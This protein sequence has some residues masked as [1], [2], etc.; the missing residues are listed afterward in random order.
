MCVQRTT[1]YSI[2]SSALLLVIR[3]GTVSSMSSC[4]CRRCGDFLIQIAQQCG[5]GRLKGTLSVTRRRVVICGVVGEEVNL[6][7]LVILSERLVQPPLQYFRK[8]YEMKYN[9]QAKK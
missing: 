3:Y 8:G 6:F 4:V 9:Q 7:V 1:L 2:P 5:V